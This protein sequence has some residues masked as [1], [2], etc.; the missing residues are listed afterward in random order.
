[1]KLSEAR[2]VDGRPTDVNDRD[3]PDDDTM[4]SVRCVCGICSV[5]LALV[6][7]SASGA[8]A[9]S[10]VA[11]KV[12]A[13]EHFQAGVRHYDLSEWEQALSEFKEAYR[14][15]PDAT[16]LYNIAQCHRKLGRPRMR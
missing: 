4:R 3:D 12:A 10:A 16:F 1:M 9:A 11:D 13:K 15:K 2:T 8:V 14:L 6:L 7:T 5:V